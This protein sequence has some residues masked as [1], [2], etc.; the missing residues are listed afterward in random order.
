MKHS[1]PFVMRAAHPHEHAELSA[2]AFA[3]KSAWGYA[4]AQMDAWRHELTVD[5]ESIEDRPTYV[6]EIDGAL[7]GF[8][9]VDLEPT[10]VELVH[11]WI[12]PPHMGRG[13]GRALLTYCCQRMAA[14][15]LDSMHIEADPH[16]EAFYLHCGARRVGERPAPIAGNPWRVLPLL[17]ISTE[18]TC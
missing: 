9:Q 17:W 12:L 4:I 13:A 11:L 10:P 1:M 16:A 6:I 7:A 18:A 14:A 8:C 3:S 5:A 15:G 2:V